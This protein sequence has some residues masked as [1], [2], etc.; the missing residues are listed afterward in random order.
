MTQTVPAS[1]IHP[2]VLQLVQKITDKVDQLVDAVESL[3]ANNWLTYAD[4]IDAMNAQLQAMLVAAPE[5]KEAESKSSKST[6]SQ[7]AN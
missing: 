4:D 6:T 7:K 3:D 5:P 1:D 2:D